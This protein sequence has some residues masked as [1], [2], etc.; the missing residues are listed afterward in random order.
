[1]ADTGSAAGRG[2]DQRLSWEEVFATGGEHGRIVLQ[3]RGF[4]NGVVGCG[5]IFIIVASLPGVCCALD[6]H[7]GLQGGLRL[8]SRSTVSGHVAGGH[9][10]RLSDPYLLRRLHVGRSQLLPL[11][12]L[13]QS[14]HVFHAD[15]GARK[16]LPPDVYRVGGGGAGVVSADRILVHERFCGVGGQEGVHREPH[17]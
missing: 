4:C 6:P 11:L 2:C 12:Q 16:Q 10:S 8:L 3:R 13:P 17:W 1:M 14:I 7:R 9:R 15:A 5:A